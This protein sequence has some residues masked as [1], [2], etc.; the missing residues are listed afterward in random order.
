MI[1][2]PSGVVVGLGEVLWDCFAHSRRPGGAPA[3]VAF[4][5]QQLGHRGTICSR[6]GEDDL[7]RDL[8]EYLKNRG[9]NTRFI[10]RDRQRPTG[11]VTVDTS[12]PDAPSYVIHENVAWDYLTFDDEMERLMKD[13]S[14]VC[15]GTLAQ[16]HSASRKTIRR[17]LE[18]ARDGLIVYDVNLRQSFYQKDWLE[19]SLKA[20][21]VVK[22]N[23]DEIAVLSSLLETG[24][25]EPRAIADVFRGRYDLSLV[26]IT[27]AENGCLLFAGDDVVD[28]PG[29][30]VEVA[31]AVG[32]GDAFTAALISARL[33]GWTLSATAWFAN[34]VGALVA[35]SQG[36][37]PSLGENLAR[38]MTEAEQR[39]SR[40]T[41]Q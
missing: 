41:R 15:F 5:A 39:A 11:S 10:Q 7:G 3:N 40:R 18:A 13:A 38:L 1:E 32:A 12:R 28:E 16:R 23:A 6:I 9:M 36:A 35:G 19:S 29:V 24:A 30:A 21:D 2:A 26:C 31:D 33:R 37:M 22:M 20:A 27:R 14:A 34:H 25:S 4:H 8:L 17:A